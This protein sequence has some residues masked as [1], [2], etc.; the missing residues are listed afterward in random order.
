MKDPKLKPNLLNLDEVATA[1]EHFQS[2][3]EDCVENPQCQSGRNGLKT[4][5]QF[6][7][8][9]RTEENFFR[10]GK[11]LKRNYVEGIIK[12][13]R[14]NMEK[15]GF[16]FDDKEFLKRFAESGKV[17]YYSGSFF[18][19]IFLISLNIYYKCLT[20]SKLQTGAQTTE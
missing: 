12:Q 1:F 20:F 2:R 11:T 19:L 4:I 15:N 3:I 10:T 17:Y 16:R 7:I 13:I 18:Y 8:L 5:L 6:Y 14:Q 9:K